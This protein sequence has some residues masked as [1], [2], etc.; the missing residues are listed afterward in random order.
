MHSKVPII[1]LMYKLAKCLSGYDDYVAQS[2]IEQAALYNF[3]E[4]VHLAQF[5][6]KQIPHSLAHVHCII[7]K[8]TYGHQD[9]SCAQELKYISINHV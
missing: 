8:D 6:E 3:P 1:T 7:I 4:E 2:R 9:Q 5:Q